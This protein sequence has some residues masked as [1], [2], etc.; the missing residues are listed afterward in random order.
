[1]KENHL[2]DYLNNHLA[3]SVGGIEVTKRCLGNS[4]GTPLGSFI[5]QLLNDL[6]EDQSVI[7]EVLRKL[8]KSEDTL[9]KLGTWALVKFAEPKL[10]SYEGDDVN[11]GRL[12]EL[13][14]ILVGSRGRLGLWLVLETVPFND[15]RLQ[16]FDFRAL[17]ARTEEHIRII[18]EY[19]LAAAHAAFL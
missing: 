17:R 5:K 11:F 10:A 18:E 2:A 14:A 1:M 9:K 12:V 16:E 8:G 13:E 4:E 19:R 7:K 3:G 6:E 15:P